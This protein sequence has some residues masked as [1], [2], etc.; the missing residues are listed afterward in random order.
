MNVGRA[1][2]L[3]L[4][5]LLL[6][7]SAHA[8]PTPPASLTASGQ[9][10]QAS[11]NW[12]VATPGGGSISCY[13]VLRSTCPGCALVLRATT[14]FA[15]TVYTDGGLTNGLV[16][17]YLVRAR[18]TLSATGG[19]AG[20]ADVQPLDSL[21]NPPPVVGTVTT[22]GAANRVVVT[23]A[24]ITPGTHPAT[25]YA[26]YRTTFPGIPLVEY[27]VG[28]APASATQFI[29]VIEEAGVWRFYTR[30]LG[31]KS[32][33]SPFSAPVTVSGTP[34]STPG[35]LSAVVRSNNVFLSWSPSAVGSFPVSGYRVYRAT[36]TG[37][38]DLPAY[39]PPVYRTIWGGLWATS[40]NDSWA[41]NGKPFYYT[42]DVYDG[43]LPTPNES[44]NS[45]QVYTT[46]GAAP[47]LS[48]H[49]RVDV[50]LCCG[51]EQLLYEISFSNTGNI[52]AQ[53]VWF[54][55]TLPGGVVWTGGQY[56]LPWSPT[57]ARSHATSIAGPWT[58]G[59]PPYMGGPPRILRWY[60][61]TIPPGASGALRFWVRT[62]ATMPSDSLILNSA[63]VTLFHG[64]G[65]LML[66]SEVVSATLW[67]VS[68]AAWFSRP[69]E[70]YAL[71]GQ[72]QNWRL[73][74]SNA[75]AF[76]TV[77]N[78]V[79]TSRT[80]NGR[81]Y[82]GGSMSTWVAG[83]G[84]V[85]SSWAPAEP[86]PWTPGPPPAGRQEPL[87]MRWTVSQ[88]PPGASG[89]V[90]WQVRPVAGGDWRLGSSVS[91][92]FSCDS[93][94]A[95]GRALAS[96]DIERGGRIQLPMEWIRL[97]DATPSRRGT[98]QSGHAVTVD[99]S[100]DIIA[101]GRD[102]RADVGSNEDFIIR[103]YDQFGALLWSLTYSGPTNNGDTASG[104]GTDPAGNI[105]V[106]GVTTI[107]N[108][109]WLV[110]KLDP[111][112]NVLWSRTWNGSGDGW[113]YMGQMGM[114]GAGNPVAV[115]LSGSVYVVGT[116]QNVSGMQ[117]WA[118]VKYDPAGNILWTRTWNPGGFL[119]ANAYAVAA[120]PA[121]NIVVSGMS[122]GG[123]NGAMLVK[124]FDSGGNELW[125]SSVSNPSAMMGQSYYGVALDRDGN[126]CAVGA[127]GFM[128][129]DW[130]WMVRMLDPAGAVLWERTYDIG[131]MGTQDQAYGAAVDVA[132]NW[133]VGGGVQGGP[134]GGR[135]WMLRKYDR[136][137][138]LVDVVVHPGL[139]DNSW[140]TMLNGVAD[141]P[142][143]Q[144]A[145][146]VGDEEM[147]EG[148]TDFALAKYAIQ[149]FDP[150]SA[151]A[152]LTANVTGFAITVGW[153]A[154]TKGTNPVAGYLV[155]R[156]LLPGVVATPANLLA[157]VWGATS[158]YYRDDNVGAGVEYFYR[159]L[160]FDDGG[161]PGYLSPEGSAVA[162]G[163]PACVH[164][165][166]DP[167]GPVCVG[168]VMTY[169]ISWS[170][171]GL[172]TVTGLTITD[173]LP[174]AVGYV[175]A[176]L[177]AW[178][179][180]DGSGTPGLTASAYATSLGGPW[181]PGE[182]ST[183]A[184]GVILRWVV[185][186]VVPGASG[187]LQF[188]AAVQ[189]SAALGDGTP[190]ANR[191]SS[192]SSIASE[193]ALSE[194][195]TSS[196]SRPALPINV[197]FNN[198]NPLYAT[199]GEL[200]QYTMSLS[201][202]SSVTVTNL[203]VMTRPGTF[204]GRTYVAPSFSALILG[205][206]VTSSAWA[207]TEFGP[208]TPGEPPDGQPDPLFVRWT[209]DQ[210]RPG[211]QG[212][213]LFRARATV[214]GTMML[215]G[216][217]VVSGDTGGPC[218]GGLPY[219]ATNTGER[220][221]PPPLA[222]IELYAGGPPPAFGTSNDRAN[223]VAVDA[224]GF[225]VAV[226]EED[227]QDLSEG[228]N[229]S[230]RRYDPSGNLGWQ[231][232]FNSGMWTTD[233]ANAV[234]VDA[235]GNAYVA[236][237]T[238][239]ADWLIVKYDSTG[240][241][242][243]NQMYN[244]PASGQDEPTG[245]A[246]DPVSGSVYVAGSAYTAA[247]FNYV[248]VIR[249]INQ[250]GALIWS[251]T[252]T[253]GGVFSPNAGGIAVD[254]WGDVV[255]TGSEQN[256]WQDLSVAMLDPDG[257][258]LWSRG[259]TGPGTNNDAGKVVAADANGN[260]YVAGTT[261]VPPGFGNQWVIL[262]YDNGGNLLWSR[263]WN[264]TASSNDEASGIAVDG[265]GN[266]VVVGKADYGMFAALGQNWMVRKYDNAGNLL[267]ADEHTGIAPT[268]PPFLGMPKSED[269]LHAVAPVPGSQDFVAAGEEDVR[270]D[271][272]S[273]AVAKYSLLSPF[274]PPATPANLTVAGGTLQ[275]AL[276]WTPAVAGNRPVSG[277]RIYRQTWAGVRPTLQTWLADV[278]GPASNAFTDFAVTAGTRVYYR[279]LAVDD[280][281]AE[282]WLTNEVDARPLS[283]AAL[284]VAIDLSPKTTCVGSPFLVMLTVTN[285][286]E[287]AANGVQVPVIPFG[288]SGGGGSTTLVGSSPVLPVVIPAGVSMT[289]T[290]TYTGTLPGYVAMT[291]TVSGTD[292]ALATAVTTGPVASST[293]SLSMAGTLAAV[294]SAA[295]TVNLG[296]WFQVALTVTNTGGIPVAG[297]TA[298]VYAGPGGG[299]V[300]AALGPVPVN[301]TSLAAGA[302]T[303]FVFSYTATGGG[304][305]TF[306]M[307][308]AGTTS[309][310]VPVA[311]AGSST[312]V[313]T[314]LLPT[315]L[316]VQ[317]QKTI[318]GS[319]WPG[320][321]VT[322]SIA[323]T[324]TG[325]AT[326][327]ALTVEDTISPVVVGSV[328]VT[329][330]GWPAAVVT[331]VGSGTRFEWTGT[332]L[333]FLPGTTTTFTISGQYGVVCVDT[334]VSNTGFVIASSAGSTTVL[335]TNPVGVVLSAPVTGLTVSK[336]QAPASPGIGGPVTYNVVVVN[337]GTMTI[338]NLVVVDTISPVVTS[339]TASEPS[340]FPTPTVVSVAGSGTRFVWSGTAATN[341]GLGASWTFTI[342]GVVGPV[343][344][345]TAV[346]N[347]AYVAGSGACTTTVLLTNGTGFAVPAPVLSVSV[348]KTVTGSP[349]PGSPMTYSIAVTNTG[350]ATIENLTVVDTISPAVVGSAAGTPA[351]WAAAVV[352]S[353]ATGTR[354]EWTGGGLA[355]YPGTTTTFTISGRYGVVCADRA[356]SN[357][358]FVIATSRC[359]TTTMTTNPV[360]AV[361][362]APVTGLTVSE[363][364]T[365][366]APG[367]GNPVT[368]RIV[369]VNSG[370]M[371][372]TNLVV[373]DTIS[374]VVT[375]AT[376]DQP[377]TFPAA[378][379]TSV[380]SGTRFLWSGTVGAGMGLGQIWTFTVTGVVGS[381]SVTTAV[382]NTAYVAGSGACTTTVMA[383]NGTGFVLTAPANLVGALTTS[384]ATLCPGVPFLVMLTVT[385]TGTIGAT[386]VAPSV[387]AASGTGGA[388][389]VD[390]P[391]PSIPVPL[392]GGASI[393]FTWTLE[394]TT[395]GTMI[396]TTT[397]TG[398]DAGSGLPVT[399]GPVTSPTVTF[400]AGAALLGAA[401]ASPPSVT[402]GEWF[403][404][405]LTVTNTG[406]RSATGVT[407]TAY[408]VPGTLVAF[409]A[410]TSGGGTITAGNTA[411]Y[412]WTFSASG[413][414]VVTFTASVNGSTG[415]GPPCGGVAVMAVASVPATVVAAVPPPPLGVTVLKTLAG[416]SWPGQPV[417]FG[418]VVTNT[419]AATITDLVVVDTVSPV[420]VGAVAT[421]PAG[422]AAPVV[423]S[424]GS[425]T[426]F[427][428]TGSGLTFY[429]GTTTTFTISG[430][431]G[432][433]CVAVAVSNT[434]FVVASDGLSTTVLATNAVG[435]TVA[436]PATGLS[437]V[438]TQTP[439]T[440]VTGS[441]VTYTVVVVNSG[442][443]TI[444]NLTLT[445]TIS[446][447]VMSATAAE[448]SG[449]PTPVVTSIASGTRF[450]W[451]GSATAS[452]GLG[453]AWTFTITGIVGPVC[454]TTAVTNTAFVTGSGA[455]TTTV[456]LTNGTGF[457]VGAPVLSVSVQKTVTGSPWPGSTVTYS[458][459]VTNTGGATI[460]ALTIEDTISPAVVGS[461]AVT[462]AGW[463]AAVVTSVA[464]GTRY[465][466]TGTGL[467]FYPGTTTTFT[468]SG[469][470]GFVCADTAVSNT[471]FVIAS[472]TCS[473]TV[474]TTNPVGLVLPAPVT[475][476]SVV[477]TQTPAS[478]GTGSPVTYRIVVANTGTMTISCLTVTDTVSP[479]V[480]GAAGDQPAAFAAASIASIG[481]GTL[482]GW[483]ACGV[484]L[485]L[486]QAFT[487]TITGVVG[488]ACIA[489]AV[490]NT[491]YALGAGVC[492]AAAVST[493][494]STGFV[495]SPPA[496]AVSVLKTITGAAGAGQP[497]SY[498]IVVTNTGEAT[499]TGLVVV[500]TVSPQ[501]TGVTPASP[502]GWALPVVTSVG[503][504]TRFIWTGAGLS[505][506][507]GTTTTF[508]IAGTVGVVTAE[509][510][511]SNTGFVVATDGC[512]A[513]V[514]ATNVAG[515]VIPGPASLAAQVAVYQ[516]AVCGGETFLVTLTVTNTGAT[517]ALALTA[518]PYASSGPGSLAFV[519]GP[520][521]AMPVP[522]AAGA[523][524][525]FTWTFSGGAAG[526][527]VL[528]TTVFATDGGSGLAV[529]KGPV[530]SSAV[531]VAVP[532]TLAVR[533]TVQ[534]VLST[535][536]WFTL[537][538]TM[539]NTGGADVTGLTATVYVDP[540]GALVTRMTDPVPPGPLTL[541]VGTST[542][543]TWTFSAAGA[544][545]VTFTASGVGTT[546]GG[547]PVTVGGGASATIQ[548]AA[549]LA[550]GL[551]LYPAAPC[552]G[553]SFMVTLTVTNTGTAM[554]S[555]VN[556]E[557][558]PFVLTGPGAATLA[559][560]PLPA[561]PATLAGGAGLTFT[562]TY[563][564][565]TPGALTF[566]T[567]V[568]GTDANSGLAAVS[569]AVNAVATI[570][571]P[572][573]VVVAASSPPAVAVGQ[574]FEV[575]LTLTNEG[576]VNVTGL[577]A[578][579]YAGPGGA[580]VS[581]QAGGWLGP[582]TL[583]GGGST[584][585]VFSCTATGAGAVTFT[586]TANGIAVCGGLPAA[587]RVSA[588][589]VTAIA[590]PAALAAALTT[591][592]KGAC[593]GQSFV[594]ML[595]VTNTGG[596]IA[597]GVVPA[598][599]RLEGPGGATF[600]DGP[601]PAAEPALAPGASVLFTWTYTGILAG[602][603][604][605]STTAAG[606]DAGT[607]F[608]VESGPVAAALAV[609]PPGVLA[610]AVSA[611][612]TTSSGAPI[613][614]ALTVTNTGGA[615]V[616]GVSPSI[617]WDPTSPVLP[618][619]GPDPSGPVTLASGSSTTFVWTFDTPTTG[620][621]T[622]SVTATGITCDTS[623]LVAG[624]WADTIVQ[625][626]MT[627]DSA[628]V[629]QASAV[630]IGDRV[631]VMFTVTNT[632]E[633]AGLNVSAA[634]P[635]VSGPGGAAFVS[636]P[637][638]PMPV[639]LLAPAESRTFSYTFTG[640][641]AGPVTISTTVT[642]T[643]ANT[644]I[645]AAA[646]VI[647][648]PFTVLAPGVLVAEASSART[649]S[650]GQVF[651]VTL[652]VTN[653]G[654][655]DVRN[656]LPAVAAGPGA[657]LV[658]LESGPS[659][660]GPLT[661]GPAGSQTFV[662]TFSA[663]GAGLVAFTA[664]AAGDTCAAT[665]VL[666]V[667]GAST[668]VQ[669]GSSLA[670]A[671]AVTSPGCV[672]GPYLFTLTVTNTGG[673]DA[674]GVTAAPFTWGGSGGLSLV[675]GPAPAMPATVPGGGT[676]VFT[677][678][679]SGA[680][681]GTMTADTDIT[682]N[683]ANT[684]D[685]L[686]PVHAAS[687]PFAIVMPGTL[688]AAADVKPYVSTGEWFAV[689]LT[690]TNTGEW[691]VTGLSPAIV[692]APGAAL[693]VQEGPPSPAG[694][695]TVA[696]GASRTFVWTFS[697]AGAGLVA[698]TPGVT[699]TTCGNPVVLASAGTSATIQI[700][701]RIASNVIAAP[702]TVS[703]G[704]LIAV[705]VGITNMGE[706]RAVVVDA[707]PVLV[708]GSGGATLAVWPAMPVN[709]D[710]GQTLWFTWSY[711]A[712][713]PG[714]VTFS[715]TVSGWDE[716]SGRAIS[717]GLKVSNPVAIQAPVALEASMA[718]TAS[719]LC[720]GD[721]TIVS[722]TVTNSGTA[723]AAE[724]AAVLPLVQDGG[725][726]LTLVA[727]PWPG[728]PVAL[729]GGA[730]ALFTWTFTGS[731]TGPVT[732]STTV[733]GID[734]NTGVT[735]YSGVALPAPVSVVTQGALVAEAAAPPTVTLGQVFTVSLTVTNTGGAVVNNLTATVFVGPGAA[736]VIRKS[737]PLP[738]GPV[739]VAGGGAQT[740]VWTYSATA[741]G[742][743]TFTATA[744]GTT[745]GAT[746]VK[747]SGGAATTVQTPPLLSARLRAAPWSVSSG[748]PVVLTL[749]VTNNGEATAAGLG[750]LP[751]V[752][753]GTGGTATWAD[754][755][756]PAVPVDLA[757]GA[758]LTFTWTFTANIPGIV[759]WTTTV[760]A[761]DGNAGWPVISN[762]AGSNTVLVQA[763]AWLAAAVSLPAGPVCTGRNF[764]VTL[765]V[766]N[767]G[768][769]TASGIASAPFVYG[770]TGLAG[771][772]AGPTPAMPF[773]LTGT[774]MRVFTWTYTGVSSGPVILTTTVTGIDVNSG[775][776]ITSGPASAG[777]LSIQ[778]PGVLAALA[779]APAFASTGQYFT[780]SLTL[781][782][783]GEADVTGIM[784][785]AVATTGAAFVTKVNG[786][787]P[788]GPFI[789]PGGASQTVVWTYS[790]TAAGAVTF[791]TSASG[792]TCAGMLVKGVDT[793]PVTVQT[794]AVLSARM[795][796][797]P[798]RISTGQGTVLTLT[799]SN[800]GQ[801]AALGV[802]PAAFLMGGPGGVTWVD[803]PFP[804][805]PA[806]VAGLGTA[807]FT[808]TFT[809]ASPGLVTWTTTLAGTD[810]NSGLG[811]RPAVA[812]SN[813]VLV[814]SAVSLAA[815][816]SLPAGPLC[817][818]RNFQVTLTVT[819]AGEATAAGLNAELFVYGGTGLVGPVAGPTPAMPFTLT[820]TAS[821]VFTWTYTGVSSGPVILTTTVTA[822]DGNGGWLVTT[823]PL[824][825]GP[826]VI[827][828]P[829]VLAGSLAAPSF[830]STGQYF[831]VSLT[832]T[833]EGEADVS[834]LTATVMATSGGAFATKVNG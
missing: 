687:A 246:F 640:S 425:G 360:G 271:D 682:G 569:G 178:A 477:K 338:T 500:D 241:E 213:I 736:R 807:V 834:V 118:V 60:V 7:L 193:P 349:W 87:L 244:G 317:V 103:K 143:T 795:V 762:A 150:P 192:T 529:T 362:P 691:D 522:L 288:I 6:P 385:N 298:T 396:L 721:R 144:D 174:G 342:T 760:T 17:T 631:L 432:V 164:K 152:T 413:A 678:T 504:G 386:S 725:G 354:Y 221:F 411:S 702:A 684:G 648:S 50:P 612:A 372:I 300:S 286:G 657:A 465:E 830:V 501:V 268:A 387:P 782:N 185:N 141:V 258:M 630:C 377:A 441:P 828:A 337:T 324:N 679:Y 606:T 596:E 114:G 674:T 393:L 649:V 299:L 63:S 121:G 24:P 507:P 790:G 263:F 166:V 642:G 273:F 467:N 804:V 35:W 791:S 536:Q 798:Q 701:A 547:L 712:T 57:Y 485:G 220:L 34:P 32:D 11:L 558:P 475:G 310:G 724:V 133:I 162:V 778:T 521:P 406:S 54:F 768:G 340:G 369:I 667:A 389:L 770:G 741:T 216:Y 688:E 555:G 772:V 419:G 188:Q 685:P 568:A 452:L 439:A 128:G 829:G 457:A 404:L 272:Q 206:T 749:T 252:V 552:T 559:S 647:A 58:A 530:V 358:G 368:Y 809:G 236:G 539:T 764:L 53:N 603:V 543:F 781:T 309:C 176:S 227:R 302:A 646:L 91:A 135:R 775:F 463:S 210:L 148:G 199:A 82:E 680:S 448:P 613:R 622:F 426:R 379:V 240:V 16:Y 661:I 237:V 67:G 203:T 120:D 451:S 716:T 546:C 290:W 384:A 22:T 261:Q 40:F 190:F 334:A 443:M 84:S 814:Q 525:T 195:A 516:A 776:T 224:L 75:G 256:A 405:T 745:C 23:W 497:V 245:V 316:A 332:G 583:A 581:R 292:A 219:T 615:D 466:W 450:A 534:P 605:L 415:G 700:A 502:P 318:T 80:F 403:T 800:S 392:A 173:T 677:W 717:G 763:G 511:L 440:P 122:G 564:A 459:A 335:V 825:A 110:V 598:P 794:R 515:A 101:V 255:M 693:V 25:A 287:T 155:Y 181:T 471:A 264:N 424:V 722:L 336:L 179:Q 88:L 460:T 304:P 235:L 819:N 134:G 12:G 367:T 565:T 400:N 644:G 556:L 767:T 78:L 633:A 37:N 557:A 10:Q 519:A 748:G 104:V 279:I 281:G 541:A 125:A 260:V 243:W 523:S 277:Y 616:T 348:Q 532:G 325:G 524:A 428:W 232:T 528:T 718:A 582:L 278:D 267:A 785:S 233:T 48:I 254:P 752:F 733:A 171:A 401:S 617:A 692:V 645:T 551:G 373:T 754:G 777:P 90:T 375:G 510:A 567:T 55:D 420:V 361:L 562:W 618:L 3:G 758:A 634:M 136:V 26:V 116:E 39:R 365:P 591:S 488:T 291:T 540:G 812:G 94:L 650:V 168:T 339:A 561:L 99:P 107:V 391:F 49:K 417:S 102:S 690:V 545:V 388:V 554:A 407:A 442:T 113:D 138:N 64:S 505:F 588:T 159:V 454:T 590:P 584:T 704:Q 284:A 51:G 15:V 783:E 218:R 115:D 398:T 514:L 239:G 735:I 81:A 614:V 730:S 130:N 786:P 621:A 158:T 70:T 697:A 308:V 13:E 137:G 438:K 409:E 274:A 430:N 31:S 578:T 833:N 732:F 303:T 139:A 296:Q 76:A 627:L 474:L 696:V 669:S 468:I 74:F 346:T 65:T 711:T 656:I 363:L 124:K 145:Y 331:S 707:S 265:A 311:V 639:A 619:T 751:F 20:P 670:A 713:F 79:L 496:L 207:V 322:Y 766:T 131:G 593:T 761:A 563:T 726:G 625:V 226:G 283:G 364:Q 229:W 472:S 355:F 509:T 329:P 689:S 756:F 771:P 641:L 801:A 487:F 36:Y 85:T 381:V 765:T 378:T 595:T 817:T 328:A 587:V 512:S 111:A 123:M 119:S 607:G 93:S 211:V 165:R 170:N 73:S 167:A 473:T 784:P 499:V 222:W 28:I 665:P 694:P 330:A 734:V 177:V 249:K 250:S 599:V 803:G 289:F 390:G 746:V 708:N 418:L 479:V 574:W 743:V 18:D 666:G 806:D 230:V 146:L 253:R 824:S 520:S 69:Q 821:R 759:T 799:V 307:T 8:V 796:A 1:I 632:G 191:A 251:R 142:G 9:N 822:T 611:P 491:A 352:T 61:G 506:Y 494:P 294:A 182:P 601:W 671:L 478:P 518:S 71:A 779:A 731:S 802:T 434:G 184:V 508:T 636:G 535:G 42:V 326:I 433:V 345:T 719:V 266:V 686:G 437:V 33:P 826:L 635:R 416:G 129:G 297:L 427:Q 651:T 810:A 548:A 517:G 662:W 41:T 347:T 169:T 187:Y 327:T 408:A 225:V 200:I 654:G 773:T 739:S 723:A 658:E 238:N 788:A 572:A 703:V 576:G 698:F 423:T 234:A 823:G 397:A 357:T 675:G 412:V 38:W 89:V 676:V 98:S 341:L 421:T 659:P 351:G 399:T 594:V 189:D 100:G 715:T 126:T 461:V 813:T 580:F 29:H 275:A 550:A 797:G 186:R 77:F 96:E 481:S 429:P 319:P 624:G 414:G 811:I 513:T 446:P 161:V 371:T 757:G 83:P 805:M 163:P 638:P 270:D 431:I 269:W 531:T 660:A 566:S 742:A 66:Q 305:V 720:L 157:T 664:T 629:A 215:Y 359:S 755:P 753:G 5:A 108:Q 353:V 586:M 592:V 740:F 183:G 673:G 321:M 344:G 214:G 19:F 816:L 86:G 350:G 231:K 217:A 209:F 262:K 212:N 628:L 314:V 201:N 47:G 683:D 571:A 469:R 699:G 737:G 643:D 276:S 609:A 573:S 112:G 560:G 600:V 663:A 154:S 486:G 45:N 172:V 175:G 453:Q 455:C 356:V 493:S 151:P 549:A 458:I 293:V 820:G 205:A 808:W 180:S 482:F 769:A 280:Q 579:V 106:A 789:L 575:S 655:D 194:E 744:A 380:A 483:S 542:T 14:N 62:S 333:S 831:T 4:A 445:D 72:L 313:T 544:G 198:P 480:T 527:A 259:W 402:A 589:T 537:A 553:Q 444:T 156:Q 681:P 196:V 59:D 422:W 750:F 366:A 30:A 709:L 818:G 714:A 140:Q 462:P 489:T 312:V 597:N 476:L 705:N 538:L 570:S 585:F 248:W 370:T 787:V 436:A 95:V 295:A 729:P 602:P 43:L 774:A 577:T 449:F 323:V 706:A 827:Q 149:A 498:S 604:S 652:T 247:P 383:T 395:A 223:A 747:A 792:S 610:A 382:T 533:T 44:G 653:T 668:T 320:S 132:G 503:S 484:A 435:V 464:T 105:I 46:P 728:M 208:W 343:C 68:V 92:T 620:L 242:Q 456:M 608:P 626:P 637:T 815:A 257:N 153:T 780:V 410:Y 394:G 285:T 97:Y 282:S 470:Y 228:A 672:G 495:L 127:E 832:V 374:P 738:A 695:V 376:G 21:I 56:W 727:G 315:V 492:A 623:T 526:P 160:A 197:G 52:L 117:A 2:A 109:D 204:A 202:G 147:L 447:V 490:S 793:V 301:L 306:T 27:E 710:A